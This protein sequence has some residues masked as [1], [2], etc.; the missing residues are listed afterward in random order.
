MTAHGSKRARIAIV[1]AG[2]AGLTAARHLRRDY[3]I[4]V[5]EA[6]DCAGGHSHTADVEVE[7]RR[8]QVDTGFIVC[9]DRNYPWFP[10]K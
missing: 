6:N 3:D 9:N 1:G 10:R 7:G 5:F 8:L 4:S 2:V